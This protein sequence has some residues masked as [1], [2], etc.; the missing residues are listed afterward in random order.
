MV[1]LSFNQ[2]ITAAEDLPGDS[3]NAGEASGETLP[4]RHTWVVWQQLMASS[5]SKSITY[6]ESTRQLAT[7]D[8]VESFWSTWAQLPQPS[9]LLTNR[10][11]LSSGDGIGFHIVD[12]VMLFREGVTPQ[13]EDPTN[14]DGG[15]LQFQFK[16]SI[17]GGRI[18]EYWNNVVLAVIGA[19]LEPN[20]FITGVRLVDKLSAGAASSAGQ[21]QRGDRGG[22]STG[23]IRIEIWHSACDHKDVQALL[24]SAEQCI[25]TRTLEG[26]TGGAPPKAEVKAHKRHQ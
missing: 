5:G 9:E 24:S 14:A 8:T 3:E 20:E 17:G 4:L 7:C 11:V 16:A 25:A 6:S 23:H 15:H 1:Y 2:F 21:N 26:R 19:T 18:D 10:M 12:A 13:W 22:N